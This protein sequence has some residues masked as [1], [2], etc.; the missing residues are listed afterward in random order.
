MA[1]QWRS[2]SRL[3]TGNSAQDRLD[4]GGLATVN[5]RAFTDLD[6]ILQPSGF[7]KG[8]RVS[9]SIINVAND[10]QIVSDDDGVTPLAYQKAYRDPIGRIVEIEL[11]KAF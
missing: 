5:V 7:T 8:A 4:F 1:T 10:R 2:A 11:R 9:L 6:R 3:I